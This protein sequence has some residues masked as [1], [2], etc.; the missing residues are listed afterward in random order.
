MK[1]GIVS[2]DDKYEEK[3]YL[4]LINFHGSVYDSIFEAYSIIILSF[5]FMFFMKM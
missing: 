3:A 1:Q 4:V 2:H 5:V